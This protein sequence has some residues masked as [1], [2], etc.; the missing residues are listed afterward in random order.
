M[1]K[2]RSFGDFCLWILM[3]SSSGLIWLSIPTIIIA[4][5]GWA[6]ILFTNYPISKAGV[7]WMTGGGVAMLVGGYL[8]VISLAYYFANRLWTDDKDF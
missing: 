8:G 3:M 4:L 5:V 6:C 1:I 2:C 7:V